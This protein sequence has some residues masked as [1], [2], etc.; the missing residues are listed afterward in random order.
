[1]PDRF[2]LRGFPVD[3]AV[4]PTFRQFFRASSAHFTPATG[5]LEPVFRLGPDGRWS[6]VQ[7]DERMRRGEAYS[8]YTRGASDYVAPF[9]LELSSGDGLEFSGGLGR[10]EVTLRNAHP[11]AK[12][13]RLEPAGPH[14]SPLL[15]LP[16]VTSDPTNAPRPLGTHEQPVTGGAAHR[17]NLG[18]DRAQLAASPA[19]DPSTGVHG[20][21]MKVSD[22]EGTQFLVGVSA[23]ANVTSD[24]TGLWTGSI[25]ITNVGPTLTNSPGPVLLGFPLRL[26][27]HVDTNGQVQLLRDVTIVTT[28]SGGVL[29]TSPVSELVTDPARLASY[30]A[31][32]IRS[33]TVRGRRLTSPHFDFARSPGQFSLALEGTLGPGNTVS[34]TLSLPGDDPGNPFRH[35]Y[36]PDHG[37]NAYPVVRS[38]RFQLTQPDP[39]DDGQ[40][41]GVYAET[42]SGLHKLPLDVT[43]SLE[44]RRVSG[45]G[46]LNA[47][48]TP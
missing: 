12:S 35:R 14:A 20:T 1:V 25:S 7:P 8:V 31:S 15:L 42:L 24:F 5:R 26:L 4:A 47:M 18:L 37:T 34:G 21:V 13:I 43:G 28:V 17:L 38:I 36:H 40:L 30:A 29:T 16:P 3:P 22:G 32:D 9:R 33:G 19:T 23:V 11:V 6:A 45:I 44:L 46:V 48:V 41:E 39:G 27:L 2:N 10:I